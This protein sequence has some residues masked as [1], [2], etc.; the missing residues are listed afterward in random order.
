MCNAYVHMQDYPD[1]ESEAG[2]EPGSG[3]DDDDDPRGGYLR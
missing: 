1:E 2:S 3:S